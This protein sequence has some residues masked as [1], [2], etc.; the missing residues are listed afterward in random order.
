[1]RA[2]RACSAVLV[3]DPRAPLLC[4]PSRGSPL[5]SSCPPATP[6][7]V[8]FAAP[9]ACGA[10]LATACARLRGYCVRPFG[11]RYCV[12][13]PSFVGA[14]PSRSRCSLLRPRAAHAA[15]LAP[16]GARG[17]AQ[18]GRARLGA[19]PPAPYSRSLWVLA[20]ALPSPS[21]R[22]RALAFGSVAAILRAPRSAFH[23]PRSAHKCNA[24]GGKTHFSKVWF[25]FMCARSC[26]ALEVLICRLLY[27]VPF[28]G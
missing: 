23:A 19:Y 6:R 18:S 9:T 7:A 21:A 10:V 1:M 13:S 28:I 3:A 12:R 22:A 11:A 25:R 8:C 27:S 15:T 5:R 20:R 26:A 14:P 4:P 2:W 24:S 16:L 17:A